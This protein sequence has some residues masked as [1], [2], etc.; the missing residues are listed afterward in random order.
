MKKT[1]SLGFT[2]VELLVVIAIIGVLIALLLPAIQ[3]AREA[4]RRMQCS[5]HVKQMG[6]AVHNFHSSK[7]GVPPLWIHYNGRL[8]FWGLL[9]PFMEQTPLYEK[10]MEGNY[11]G[12]TRNQGMD[13]IF[14]HDW[15]NSLSKEQQDSFGSVNYYKCPSRRA[16][17]Q[18]IDAASI[19]AGPCVDYFVLVNHGRTPDGYNNTTDGARFQWW[20]RLNNSYVNGHR[21]PVRHAIYTTPNGPVGSWEPRDTMAWWSDGTSNQIVLGEKHIPSNFVGQ[22]DAHNSS[23]GAGTPRRYHLDCSFLG[24][25]IDTVPEAAYGTNASS[26]SYCPH[27]IYFSSFVNS[28]NTESQT[29]Y[30]LFPL[31][32]HYG[33][34][35][36]ASNDIVAARAFALGSNHPDTFHV[37]RGDGSVPSVSISTNPNILVLLTVVDDGANA[38]LP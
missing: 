3:A 5:N 32:P 31:S 10:A 23:I 34:D 24:L 8:S 4:A 21:G 7:N 38:V 22:C 18:V 33:N 28:Q 12:T 14:N 20:E 37:L 2:L 26:S 19:A 9:F 6:I 13:R 15:W 27:R 16:G 17:V 29:G 35:A 36:S 1:L 30:K 11:G 25:Q